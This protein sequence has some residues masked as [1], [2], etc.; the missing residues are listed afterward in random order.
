MSPG[1]GDLIHFVDLLR[2]LQLVG[3][4]YIININSIYIDFFAGIVKKVEC[5]GVM[6]KKVQ[7]QPQLQILP[8]RAGAK[9]LAP[10]APC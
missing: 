4:S 2:C 7:S 1:V 10:G 3:I 8:A 9:L 6:T 5:K